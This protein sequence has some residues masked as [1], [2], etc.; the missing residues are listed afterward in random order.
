MNRI[1]RRHPHSTSPTLTYSNE[2]HRS[3]RTS[4]SITLTADAAHGRAP[5]SERNDGPRNIRRFALH[6]CLLLPLTV[7]TDDQASLSP[8]REQAGRSQ[9]AA[10]ANILMFRS[11]RRNKLPVL[12][13]SGDTAKLTPAFAVISQSPDGWTG[14]RP[15]SPANTR[16]FSHGTIGLGARAGARRLHRPI[17]RMAARIPLPSQPARAIS[18]FDGKRVVFYEIPVEQTWDA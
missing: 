9:P 7:R 18:K 4:A 17:W 10:S 12:P 14:S 6:A 11:G 15:G 16:R 13:H 3:C 5:P 1:D 2:H 8:G